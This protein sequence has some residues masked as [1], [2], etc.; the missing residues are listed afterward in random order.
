MSVRWLSLVLCATLLLAACGSG[1]TGATDSAPLVE[2]QS[3]SVSPP[4]LAVESDPGPGSVL[5]SD[6]RGESEVGDLLR[7]TLAFDGSDFTTTFQLAAPVPTVGTA[8]L[9]VMVSSKSGDQFR[10]LGVNFIDGRSYVWVFDMDSTTQQNLDVSP[11]VVGTTV[12]AGFPA[13][14]IA[15]LGPSFNWHATYS[16]NGDDVDEVPPGEEKAVFPG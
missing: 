14:A 2:D 16:V 3:E 1:E 9:S 11:R 6:A 7:V 5:L 12:S 8:L 10:Q 15:G 13:A 4:D